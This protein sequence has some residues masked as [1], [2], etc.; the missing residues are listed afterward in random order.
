[1]KFMTVLSFA[2]F[3]QLAFADLD[4][5]WKGFSDPEIMS[6][7]FT[8]RLSDLPLNGQI[9][10]DP[11]GWSGDY[12]SAKKGGIN[13]RW[14]APVKT[15]YKLESP[16]KALAMSLGQEELRTLAPTEKFDL[17]MGRYSY[18]LVKEAEGTASKL[19]SDWAGICHGWAPATLYHNEPLAKVLTNPD[20]IQVPFG[21][22]DIK[23]L[24]SYYYAF[25]NKGDV[26]Q[27][28]LR[29]FFGRWLGGAGRGCGEDLNAGAFHIVLTNKI[30]LQQEGFVMDIDRWRQVW[31][32]PAIAYESVI[33]ADNLPVSKDAAKYAVKEM[34][35]KTVVEHADGSKPTW[36]SVFGTEN[37]KTDKQ[38]YVYRIEINSEGKIIGGTW[39]SANR[40]DFIWSITPVTEFRGLLENL[41][42]LLND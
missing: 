16:S 21:S 40:P 20:G 1:M 12:W 33:L 28:G 39:E 18:P 30:G 37:Q 41:P 4:E 23:A 19:A 6:S 42:A 31:N 5:A 32:H 14:N 26:G 3:A 35:I 25:Y 9:A 22:G 2:L 36:E 24:L 34:R 7:G 10:I 27:V 8:H 38:E 13:Y 17:L 11:K 29:C 15:G